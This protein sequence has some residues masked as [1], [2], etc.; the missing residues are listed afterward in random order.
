MNPNFLK[1]ILNDLRVLEQNS[2]KDDPKNDQKKEYSA[3][4]HYIQE[5][6]KILGELKRNYTSYAPII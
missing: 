2:E 6:N 4:E 3:Y 1:K 5:Y